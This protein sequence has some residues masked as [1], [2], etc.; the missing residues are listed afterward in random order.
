MATLMRLVQRTPTQRAQNVIDLVIREKT[1]LVN[2]AMYSDGAI[3][4]QLD[5]YAAT[6]QDEQQAQVKLWNLSGK[7]VEQ[8]Q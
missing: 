6:L 8:I 3:H 1:Q 2:G 5:A 4:Q 7:L